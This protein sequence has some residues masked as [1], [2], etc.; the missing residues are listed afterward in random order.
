ML[1]VVFNSLSISIRSNVF[2]LFVIISI[3]SP[4]YHENVGD[5]ILKASVSQ[6]FN[7]LEQRILVGREK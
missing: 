3:Y 1:V 4:D 6:T 7:A 5:F 2:H